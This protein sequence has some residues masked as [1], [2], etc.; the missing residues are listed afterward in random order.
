MQLLVPLKGLLGVPLNCWTVASNIAIWVL[1]PS[2]SAVVLFPSSSA[3]VGHAR[4]TWIMASTAVDGEQCLETRKEMFD[5]FWCSV[6]GKNSKIS[7]A[8][9]HSNLK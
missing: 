3:V 7:S 2:S 5:L 4:C 9:E 8:Q 1:F 6:V